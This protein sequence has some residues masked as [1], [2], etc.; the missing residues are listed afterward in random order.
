MAACDE[1][2]A[3]GVP[4][5]PPVSLRRP[6]GSLRRPVSLRRPPG[7]LRP[8]VVSA[9]SKPVPV[10]TVTTNLLGLLQGI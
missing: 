7:S 5:P 1:S 2:A 10:S 4:P 3:S 8:V 6:P 9:E